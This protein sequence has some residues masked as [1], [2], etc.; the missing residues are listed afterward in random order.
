L[1]E[2]GG[3][4]LIQSSYDFL[5]LLL[6][7]GPFKGGRSNCGVARY[8]VRSVFKQKN[9]NKE[10]ATQNSTLAGKKGKNEG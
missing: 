1:E 10:Y 2:G 9:A 7:E 6:V 5:G 8:T 3:R 4:R